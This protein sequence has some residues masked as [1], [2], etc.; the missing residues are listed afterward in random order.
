M[1]VKS[2]PVEDRFWEKIVADKGSDC[3][4][5]VGAIGKTGY[6]RLLLKTKPKKYIYAHRLSYILHIN[7]I[8]NDLFVLHRCDNRACVNPKHLFLG[9]AL[10]NSQDMK[11]KQRHRHGGKHQNAKLTERKVKE[12]RRLYANGTRQCTLMRK[13]GVSR[14]TVC[15]IV[16]PRYER[17]VHV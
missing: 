12:M 13:F 16:N 15:N 11:K 1:A 14:A 3:W 2:R 4:L 17:W 7:S 10:D 5:W 6:G 9:T 8:P